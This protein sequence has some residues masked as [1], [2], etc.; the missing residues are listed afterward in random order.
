MR[1]GL[2]PKKLLSEMNYVTDARGFLEPP[3]GWAKVGETAPSQFDERA[4]AVTVKL[5]GRRR[6]QWF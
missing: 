2:F 5:T 6:Y 3:G 4:D 1:Y